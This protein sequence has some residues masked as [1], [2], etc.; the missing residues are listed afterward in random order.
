MHPRFRNLVLCAQIIF[1][2]FGPA[3]AAL[4]PSIVNPMFSRQFLRRQV[5]STPFKINPKSIASLA[6]ASA[7]A[8][9]DT[10]PMDST[11]EATSGAAV[12]KREIEVRLAPCY[13]FRS[14]TEKFVE[15]L[16]DRAI[17]AVQWAPRAS[18]SQ[19][20]PK[21]VPCRG[22]NRRLLVAAMFSFEVDTLR[23]FLAQHRGIADVLIVESSQV[24][25]IQETRA[26][27]ALWNKTIHRE[28]SDDSFITS[29]TCS[30]GNKKKLWDAEINQNMCM[31]QAIHARAHMYDIVVVGS[32]DEILGQSALLRLK[33]CPLPRLPTSSA[34]GMPLGL[35]DRSFRT[36]WHYPN[37][38]HSFT[39]PS[40]YPATF[41]GDFVR[42]FRPLG[43]EPVVGGLHMTNYCFLPNIVLKELTATEYGHNM[44]VDQLCQ[45][46]IGFW[47][48]KC[49]SKNP[50]GVRRVRSSLSE[51][52]VYFT[53]LYFT[54]SML[55]HRTRPGISDETD[56]PCA[57]S[58]VVFPAWGGKIDDR[59]KRFWSG[60]CQSFP[61]D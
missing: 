55:R 27:P 47:K 4:N 10:K 19:C 16:Y 11:L 52:H 49:Y 56:I 40:I 51:S 61:K 46:S 24:H 48:H 15:M 57:L 30:P 45:R 31:S 25:N 33:H 54:Y 29:V 13:D 39:L 42:S 44:S 43:P 38:Q 7:A 60:L 17:E 28:F 37:R 36:D 14:A 8:T 1:T 20:P 32:A 26:K 34:I 9:T 22:F 12:M 50:R 5:S 21:E 35:L 41:R 59:E 2:L 6:A 58:T 53:L 3:T 23:V 18:I